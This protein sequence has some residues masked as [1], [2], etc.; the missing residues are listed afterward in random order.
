MHL[1]LVEPCKTVENSSFPVLSPFNTVFQIP[2]LPGEA[3]DLLALER[4]SGT[5]TH[6]WVHAGS[7]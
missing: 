7:P 5:F 6:D 2:F 4:S 3:Y 1:N